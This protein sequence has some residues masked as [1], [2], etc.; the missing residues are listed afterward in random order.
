[1]IEII[2]ILLSI[3]LILVYVRIGR[4]QHL[5]AQRIRKSNVEYKGLSI[6]IPCHNNVK[7]LKSSIDNLTNLKY[8]NLEII[9]I[10]DGSTDHT[11]DKL[12]YLLELEEYTNQYLRANNKI[13][14]IYKSKKIDDFYVVD[15]CY[16][17]KNRSL[18]LGSQLSSKEFIVTLDSSAILKKD[19]LFLINMNLQDESVIATSGSILIKQGIDMEGEGKLTFKEDCKFIE[20]AQFMEYIATF[21]IM[22]NSLCKANEISIISSSFG[23]FNREIMSKLGCFKHENTS[24]ID[25]S[26]QLNKYAKENNKKI[27]YDDRAICFENGS[28][29]IFSCCA[30]KATLQCCFMRTLKRHIKFLSGECFSNKLFFIAFFSTIL[31]GYASIILTL[32]G[33]AY[34]MISIFLRESIS[35]NTY[36]QIILGIIIF[37]LYSI[38]NIR[39][40]LKNNLSFKNIK[41]YKIILIHLYILIVYKPVM[42]FTFLY[43]GIKKVFSKIYILVYKKKREFS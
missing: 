3:I 27:T 40:A 25:I 29:S 37:L 15:K 24:N 9:F 5:Q 12:K 43:A 26:L 2:L 23:V 17:G 28:S 8:P 39:V 42:I 30:K 21:Y 35:I 31:L 38:V 7:D 20:Y 10:N 22:R 41:K 19:A 34:L 18:N 14:K 16:E 32:L 36:L 6:L 13:K 11:M 33:V 1:M 4:I